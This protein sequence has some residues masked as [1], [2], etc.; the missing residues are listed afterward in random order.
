MLG[1]DDKESRATGLEA[2]QEQFMVRFADGTPLTIDNAPVA[3]AVRTG[4]GQG[5]F[6]L[7]V[8][9]A[10]GSEV[11]TRTHCAPYF[12]DAGIVAGAVV[13]S[14]VIDPADLP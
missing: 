4:R 3:E 12:D 13:T 2:S 7:V 10:D 5:P 8:M 11:F 9:R 1:I 14:E 6:F